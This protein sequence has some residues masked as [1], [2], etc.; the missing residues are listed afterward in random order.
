[1]LR[2]AWRS[3]FISRVCD[4]R[5]S[6]CAGRATSFGPKRSS[7]TG[8]LCEFRFRRGTLLHASMRPSFA[9]RHCG[10][11]D[12]STGGALRSGP[13]RPSLTRGHCDIGFCR[14]APL[15]DSRRPRVQVWLCALVKLTRRLCEFRF[16]RTSLTRDPTVV[17]S[18]LDPK[19]SLDTTLGRRSERSEHHKDSHRRPVVERP[20]VPQVTR[21]NHTCLTCMV[22]A[23]TAKALRTKRLPMMPPP[24]HA[25]QNAC[26]PTLDCA[27][28]TSTTSVHTGRQS[29]SLLLTGQESAFASTQAT[30]STR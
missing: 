8:S 15:C 19:N 28:D 22:P 12:H 10:C 14:G 2:K 29:H 16:C 25:H 6:G 11:C 17:V 5:N 24:W 1:M 4:C 7:F 13:R 26:A 27:E 23:A 3:S 20:Q 18:N 21:R 30:H 9:S